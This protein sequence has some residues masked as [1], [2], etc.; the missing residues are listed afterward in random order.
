MQPPIFPSC[1]VHHSPP[2]ANA[3]L[4]L[5]AFG[6][7]FSIDHE[8]NQPGAEDGDWLVAWGHGPGTVRYLPFAAGVQGLDQETA[9]MQSASA[10]A[11]DTVAARWRPVAAA[12][13]ARTLTLSCDTFTCGPFSFRIWSPY[14]RIPRPSAA[15]DLRP[16]SLPAIWLEVELDNS[17]CDLEA[18]IFLGLRWRAAGRMR[19]IAWE[20]P[21]LAGVALGERWALA[22]LVADGAF[23]IRDGSVAAAVEHA[24]PVLRMSGLEGGIALRVPAGERRVLRACLAW[25]HHGPATQGVLTTYAFQRF[26]SDL[27][28]VCRTA[29]AE[30]PQR[31]TAAA[32]DDAG[33]LARCANRPW[34]AAFLA[35]AARGYAANTQLLLDRDGGIHWCV[36]E[37]Q[38]W[39]RNTLDLAADHLAWELDRHPWVLGRIMADHR[40]R[41]A[42]RDRI[43]LPGETGFPHAGG[44]SFAHDQGNCSQVA[45]PGT[46]GY[47]RPGVRGCY[48]F[49]TL[50]QLLNGI[51]VLAAAE[52]EEPELWRELLASLLRRD[53]P[54]PARRSGILV[55]ESDRVGEAGAEITTYDALDHSL[56]A[57]SGSVYI[58]LK[59]L[60]AALLIARAAQR[61][62][63]AATAASARAWAA[64][65]EA[66]WAARMV[67][68]RYPAN[69]LDPAV[70]SRVLAALDP[71]AMPLHL[72]LG[73]E[74]AAMPGLRTHLVLHA[75]TCLAEGCRHPSGGLR[76]SS[77]AEMTWPSKVVLCLHVL[78]W[79]GW[80]LERDESAALHELQRWSQV[81]AAHGT[82]AD[83]VRLDQDA[84][85]GGAYYPRMVSSAVLLEPADP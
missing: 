9:Q 75:R 69:A 12:A 64:Q 23:T 19:P 27:L 34:L 74:L 78:A 37:G 66:A 33:L 71:F 11:P 43:R 38:Y 68:G 58:G 53:H 21:S 81:L 2:G 20:D 22:A 73:D 55:A 57:A 67:D 42:Y 82:I 4:T 56:M 72:G 28:A 3:S 32:Q 35:Q 41:H 45:P 14:P 49:M 84:V 46:G 40:A 5:G 60:C 1:A 29:L 6:R 15:D 61:G 50:E 83:Q 8:R 76:L 51:Y 25:Q 17:A 62:G 52:V 24:R 36:L 39:W 47:E 31:L 77:T 26:W 59:G 18:T 48:S 10:D 13:V 7:G 16:W 79:L 65:A 63:D 44:L 30:A 54:D 85:V 80:D 70:T